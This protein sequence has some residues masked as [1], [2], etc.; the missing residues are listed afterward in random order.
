MSGDS[1]WGNVQPRIFVSSVVED[2]EEYR[3]AARRAIERAGGEPVLVNEDFPALATSPR[4]ACLDAVD[5]CDLYLA[6]IGARGGWT[7][8]SGILVVEEEYHR[9]RTRKLPVLVFL[10]QIARDTHAQRLVDKLSDYLNGQFRLGFHTPAEL[11][12]EI[13]RALRTVLPTLGRP[14]MDKSK[15][16][17]AVSSPHEIPN[18]T[19][20]R[21]VVA[22]EREE[23]VV[24]PVKLGSEDFVN[25]IFEIGHSRAV[26][27]FSYRRS[28]E[29]HIDRHSLVIEQAG[30]RG[31]DD[32]VEAVRLE[33]TESGQIA[34]DSNVTGRVRRGERHSLMDTMCIVQE[35]LEAVLRASFRFVASFLEEIDPY[36]RHQRSYYNVAL[37]GVGF[38]TF[39]KVPKEQSSYCMNVF[40]ED[41]P[42]VAFPE[43][44][45][46]ARADLT[47]PEGEITRIIILLSRNLETK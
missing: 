5:S 8:P 31:R 12:V 29:Y 19:S 22:P 17:E 34:I 14:P 21:F 16:M 23:E 4:K 11:Q 39:V 13:E 36:K 7:T 27:L 44:R 33:L 26:R 1:K 40:R 46:I 30:E 35:D 18:E 45:L 38:R 25:R 24:D 3:E 20:L 47:A 9:A 42:I 10:Q 15:L 41:R 43:P 2:F 6:I 37:R 28:K 32:T